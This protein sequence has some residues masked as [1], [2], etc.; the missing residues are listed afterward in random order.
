MRR[1]ASGRCG[2][3]GA[4]RAQTLVQSRSGRTVGQ[5]ALAGYVLAEYIVLCFPEPVIESTPM[6]F[7]TITTSF[8]F[9]WFPTPLAGE[10]MVFAR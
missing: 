2:S 4:C 5:N 9:Y 1:A 3:R 10:G 6:L 8:S 7:M